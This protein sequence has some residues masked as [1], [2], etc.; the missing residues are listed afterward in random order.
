[1]SGESSGPWNVEFFAEEDGSFPV[2]AWLDGVTEGVRGRIIARIDL[3]KKGGPTLDYPYTAQIEGRLR[4]VR[5]RVG[6]TR[7]RVLYFFDQHRTAVLLHGFT[8]TT[9]TV[10]E[11]DKRIGRARMAQHEARQLTKSRGTDRVKGSKCR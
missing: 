10:E 7:Y 11:G 3:L 2:R 5:V 6:K 1:V 8:K 4:E 9:A